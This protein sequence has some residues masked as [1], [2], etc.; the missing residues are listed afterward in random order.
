VRLKLLFVAIAGL[1]A[2]SALNTVLA[3]WAIQRAR[4]WRW[5]IRRVVRNLAV[6][7]ATALV[8]A[9][10]A[11]GWYLRRRDLTESSR[12]TVPGVVTYGRLGSLGGRRLFPADNA[13]NTPIDQSPIDSMSSRYMKTI[14]ESV[15]L[16]PDF[17]PGRLGVHLYGIPYNVVD[18]AHTKQYRVPFDYQAESDD[19]PYPIPAHAAVEVGGDRHLLIVDATGWRLYELF[20]AHTDDGG[21][22]WQA[23]AGA[24][25]DL[26]SDVSRPNNRTSADAAGLPI[27]AGL[28]RA[29]EVYDLG[30]IDHALRFTLPLTQAAQVYPAR[31][32]ASANH[33]ADVPPMG[34]RLRLNARVDAGS[35]PPGAAVI[36]RALQK[37][38]MIL[39]D[40]GGS[41]F[42]SGTAD[43]R[44]KRSDLLA[45]TRL[46]A[47]D[48][49]VI[50]PP[51]PPTS[52]TTVWHEIAGK[53][54][55]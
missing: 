24:T 37:Y 27:M 39:A 12:P 31:H 30:K 36:V 23:G 3:V 28:A 45:L 51:P 18:G 41:L 53:A 35:F 29:D 9:V 20:S 55:P 40:N 14:G 33:H 21:A 1:A 7:V 6:G 54:R 4:P 42:L 19:V 34:T 25:W 11:G 47:G 50:A 52:D 48:F 13:W 17:G 43:R 49:D 22:S 26:N 15:T 2:W 10:L 16:H 44:W 5:N 46:H 8:L 38:G 32:H